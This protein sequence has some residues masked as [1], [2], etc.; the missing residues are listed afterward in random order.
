MCVRIYIY[1]YIS[2]LVHRGVQ[3]EQLGGFSPELRAGRG[4]RLGGGAEGGGGWKS[5]GVENLRD[6]AATL[7]LAGKVLASNLQAR[8]FSSTSPSAFSPDLSTPFALSPFAILSRPQHLAGSLEGLAHRLA[9][10]QREQGAAIVVQADP[11]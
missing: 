3:Q 1:I 10:A 4:P 8:R 7:G 2:F 6:A 5:R 9:L 11:E